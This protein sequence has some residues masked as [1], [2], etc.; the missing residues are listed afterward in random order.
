MGKEHEQTPTKKIYMWQINLW[1]WSIS[2]VIREMLIK[3]TIWCHCTHIR[4]T[5]IPNTTTTKYYHLVEQKLLSLIADGMQNDRATLED[6]LSV[7]YKTKYIL[8]IWSRNCT[9]WYLPKL[10]EKL[11]PHKNLY[12]DFFSSF[13]YNFPNLK[14]TKM[15]FSRWMDKRWYIQVMEYYL[16]L[17][18]EL[19]SLNRNGELD[20]LIKWKKPI[21]KG[22]TLHNSNYMTLW[23][24]QNYGDSKK[25]SGWSRVS[26]LIVILF[27]SCTRCYHW[28]K[29]REGCMGCLCIISYNSMWIYNCF[30]IK[31]LNIQ[32]F[33]SLL[34]TMR[35][36][37]DSHKLEDIC[38]THYALVHR[39]YKE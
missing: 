1:K 20:V 5:K 13:I 31:I 28:E 26:F 12:T 17:K 9:P 3:T 29:L 30:K 2:Y 11:C 23:K 39:I 18:N 38:L 34:G 33:Y 4:I 22:H 32:H 19:S 6:S 27:Y 25:I 14:W 36:W 8:S 16:A 10:A 21:W 35:Q 7:H 37:K 24:R 15:S